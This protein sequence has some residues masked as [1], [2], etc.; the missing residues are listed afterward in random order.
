MR[1]MFFLSAFML[2]FCVL[3]AQKSS[4][5]DSLHIVLQ[6]VTV[7]SIRASDKS[8]VS[9]TNVS[10]KEISKT[11]LGQDVPYLLSLTPNFITTSDAGTGIGYTGYR[12]RGTDANRVNVTVNGIPLNDSESHGVFFVNMPDF[13]SS[14]SSVQIQR[15]VGTSTN[16]AAAFGASINMQTEGLNIKPY[17]ELSSTFGSFNTNK[18]NVKAGTGLLNNQWAFDARLSNITSDGYIDRAFVD[19][20]SYY[21]SAA[22]FGDKTTLRLLNF[23]GKERTYQAWNG[24]YSGNLVNNRTYNELGAYVDNNGVDQFYDN[25]TDNYQQTHY[26]LHLNQILSSSL[27]LNA[28]AHYT[29]GKGYYEEYKKDR[30]FDEYSLIP[31]T[32][33]GQARSTTDL[34]RRKWLDNHFGG[35]VFA[36]NYQND[37]LSTT[38]GGGL[39]RYAGAHY[40]KVIWVR[41]AQ[42]PNPEHE[43]YRSNSIKDDGNIYLKTSYDLFKSLNLSADLQYRFVRH[44]MEGQN[45]KFDWDTNKMRPL[46][47]DKSF[48]FFNPKLGVTY[49]IDKTQDVYASWS[50]AN[51][52]PNRNNFTESG[53]NDQ[54][55][56]ETLFDTELGYRFQDKDYSVG[57]NAYYMKYKNQLVLT[58]KISEIGELLT[59]N[60]EDSY[61]AG[62]EI[63]AGGRL[64]DHFRWDGNISISTNKILNYHSYVSVYDPDYDVVG[65]VDSVY[66]STNI[67]YSP[68]VVTNSVFTYTR[69]NFEASI[70]SQ[71]V[72]KQYLDNTSTEEKSVNSYIVNNLS[73]K[74][75]LPL[76]KMKSVDFQILVNNLFNETYETGGYAWTEMYP[77]DANQYHYKYLYP[78]AGIHLLGSV[79]FKF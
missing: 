15:G 65:T 69:G 66:T 67:G 32:L 60:V 46:D 26:Q 11:N 78:Q 4:I 57:I 5:K 59:S 49:K 18:N 28:S 10:S 24:V 12:V 64:S 7:S 79:T 75:S 53:V 54:P 73:L 22:Y 43:Y 25:Q 2:F 72:G 34:I 16:G 9:F 29:R 37:G 20:S 39:N 58:G 1:K 19:M 8:A 70:M 17:A 52:E 40:G 61:R 62:I 71:F 77:G 76:K 27:F 41:N 42:N 33:N 30:S 63:V 21:L 14:L 68:N 50:V 47:I 74:Y 35:V 38:F 31:D 51:R 13:A 55:V 6:E 48:H 3:V 23:G 56:A 45:D 44:R 36:L